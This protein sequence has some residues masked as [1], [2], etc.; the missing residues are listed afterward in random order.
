MSKNQPHVPGAKPRRKALA[1]MRK[2]FIEKSYPRLVVFLI[3][4]ASGIVAFAVSVLTLAFGLDEMGLR[5]FV[6]TA[7][8]YLAFLLLIRVWIALHRMGKNVDLGWDIDP[9]IPDLGETSSTDAA[10]GGGRSGGGGAS[11]DWDSPSLDVGTIDV[12]VDL[13]AALP[14]ILAVACLLG[15]VLAMFYVVSVAPVLLAEVALDAALVMGIYRKLRKEDARHWLGSALRHTWLPATIAAVC[16]WLTGMAL[17]WAI[18]DAR[19]IG[20]VVRA[21]RD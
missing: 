18:P 13:D 10:F 16:L 19:S 1:E 14:V 6:A 3:L 9:G 17:Q 4:A 2:R 11:G 20:D 15:S 8:G 12:D 21:F 7:A 5:Y